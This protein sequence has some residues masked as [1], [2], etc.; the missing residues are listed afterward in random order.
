M[1]PDAACVRETVPPVPQECCLWDGLL[2]GTELQPSELHTSDLHITKDSSYPKD[3]RIR[4]RLSL[5][6]F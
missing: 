1:V 5:I 6:K 2:Y 4:P 3:C